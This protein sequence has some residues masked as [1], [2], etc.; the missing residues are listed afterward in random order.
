M[1]FHNDDDDDDDDDDERRR[2]TTMTTTT[3]TAL[4]SSTP[5]T[6]KERRSEGTVKLSTPT[7]G[8]G[9]IGIGIGIIT[10]V[11]ELAT[12]SREC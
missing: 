1:I 7:D 2:T 12:A 5:P 11:R 6:T 8:G 3:T 9:V 4:Q 10:A